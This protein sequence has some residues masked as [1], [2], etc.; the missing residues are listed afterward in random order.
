M[1]DV[2]IKVLGD[3]VLIEKTKPMVESTILDIKA[4]EGSPILGHVIKVGEAVHNVSPEETIMFK[5]EHAYSIK[6]NNQEYF[7]IR[8]YDIIAVL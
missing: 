4:P 3:R 1:K 5:E 7:I 2:K 8:D 6:L